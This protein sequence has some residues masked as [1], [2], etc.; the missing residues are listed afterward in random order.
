MFRGEIWQMKLSPN[1]KEGQAETRLVVIL[2]SDALGALPLKII[3]PL[4]SWRD[5]YQSAPWMVRIP[6]VLHSGL[7]QP[8][9]A[10]A[11][12][13]RSVSTSRL[14][15]RLGEIPDYFVNSIAEAVDLILQGG[16]IAGV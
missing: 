7:E 5:E 2:S 4:T 11:L 6:P 1:P 14:L 12:Q 9:A 15:T 13:V 16:R 3:V 10:D 8:M